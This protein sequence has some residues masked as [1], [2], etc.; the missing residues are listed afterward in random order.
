M[1]QL[2][3]IYANMD[4]SVDKQVFV[5]MLKEYAAEVGKEFLPDVYPLI[6]KMKKE[7]LGYLIM[8]EIAGLEKR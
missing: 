8:E 6:E 2:L 3:E 5:A 1:R 7:K 4:I